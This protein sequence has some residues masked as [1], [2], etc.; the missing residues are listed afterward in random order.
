VLVGSFD[1]LSV[2]EGGAVADEGDELGCVERTP[3]A[4]GGSVSDK[5]SS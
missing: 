2:D 1:E 3:A 4:L 5:T